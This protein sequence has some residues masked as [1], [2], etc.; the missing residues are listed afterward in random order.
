MSKQISHLD[1]GDK[2]VSVIQK[3]KFLTFSVFLFFST[4]HQVKFYFSYSA[5]VS[6]S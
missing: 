1:L 3:L 2:K 6:S 5:S 4:I